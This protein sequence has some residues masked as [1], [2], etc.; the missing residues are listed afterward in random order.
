[1][2]MQCIKLSREHLETRIDMKDLTQPWGMRGRA[3]QETVYSNIKKQVGLGHEF[4]RLL[5]LRSIGP[6]VAKEIREGIRDIL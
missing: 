1:M 2:K 6:L 3:G 4:L 5:S